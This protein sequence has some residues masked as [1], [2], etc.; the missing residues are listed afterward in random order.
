MK[1]VKTIFAILALVVMVSSC[2]ITLPVAATS[3]AIG[4]KVGT[5]TATG[6]LGIIFFDADASIRTAA[7]NG[8]ISKISTVDIKHTNVLNIIVTYQTIVTG[9]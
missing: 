2:S 5:A 3:N 6:Y 1:K 8:G 4:S 9:E 7:K